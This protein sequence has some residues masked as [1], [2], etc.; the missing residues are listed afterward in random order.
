RRRRAR[1]REEGRRV[2]ARQVLRRH[3]RAGHLQQARQARDLVEHPRRVRRRDLMRAVIGLG[4][5]LAGLLAAAPAQADD[6][7]SSFSTKVEGGYEIGAMYGSPMHGGRLRVGLG[8]QTDARAFWAT[9]SGRYGASFSGLGV[10]DVR[11]G[12]DSELVRI[13]IFHA[14]G[15]ADLGVHGY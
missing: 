12:A 11:L 9:L 3:P 15:G 14:G 10:W 2:P 6:S 7:A 5:M 1:H 8:S 4:A 13:G